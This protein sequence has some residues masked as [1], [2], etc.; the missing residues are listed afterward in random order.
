MFC[1]ID[2]MM[3]GESPRLSDL[4]LPAPPVDAMD[5][6]YYIPPGVNG[7][8]RGSS[9]VQLRGARARRNPPVLV[10]RVHALGQTPL[11]ALLPQPCTT[12]QLCRSVV[13][14]IL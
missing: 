11:P 3:R 13:N 4:G 2:E 9:P 1:S 12:L 6:D 14:G 10:R 8:V 7:T 5:T